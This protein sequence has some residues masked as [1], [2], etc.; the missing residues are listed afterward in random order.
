MFSTVNGPYH[1]INAPFKRYTSGPK[2][3]RLIIGDW[4]RP[5]FEYLQNCEWEFTEKVD[6]TNIRI[7]MDH[8]VDWQPVVTVRG[9]SNSAIVPPMLLEKLRKD[10]TARRWAAAALTGET[11]LYGEGY[12]WKIQ[13]GEGY[14]GGEPR[15]E[16][17][18]F[19]VNVGGWWLSRENVED[20]GKKLGIPVVPLL[21][22]GTLSDAIN[23]VSNGLTWDE[24]NKLTNWATYARDDKMH[25]TKHGLVSRIANIP[26]EGIVAKP[27]VPLFDRHGNRIITKI[28]AVDFRKDNK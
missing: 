7:S 26:A 23:I 24:N 1:K 13:N 15:Q 9:R 19:D 4:A 27:V 20:I 17:I 8:D 25:Y 10:I 22:L 14:V 11:T 3:G 6:G 12:G 28:K 21:G 2:K 5:E 16:F 18:L